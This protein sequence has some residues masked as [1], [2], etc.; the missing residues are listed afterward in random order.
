MAEAKIRQCLVSISVST[1][2]LHFT[3][4][5]P[6]VGSIPVFSRPLPAARSRSNTYTSS[7][8]A[9]T[10]P[11]STDGS[12]ISG[13]SQ[14]R[15]NL[16]HLDSLLAHSSHLPMSNT[17]QRGRGRCFAPVDKVTFVDTRLGYHDAQCTKQLRKRQMFHPPVLC[18]PSRQRP[19][20]S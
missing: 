5:F 20:V 11:L 19:L 7:S 1:F 12:S 13:G 18:P 4:Y 6:L 16:A 17:A 2:F 3:I 14:S 8:G 15:I 10:P 9:D